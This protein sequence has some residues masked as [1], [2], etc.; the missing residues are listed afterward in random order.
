[1]L[2][3]VLSVPECPNVDL[4]LARLSAVL[5]SSE[6]S[7]KV[8]VIEDEEE[9]R[10]WHMPGSPTLL[11]DGVDPFAGEADRPSLSCR[12]HRGPDGG[13]SGTPSVAELRSV[14]VGSDAAS[15][16]SPVRGLLDRGGRGRLAP[17][18]RG[19]R[20]VQQAIVRAFAL[21]GRP[22][23]PDHL[24]EVARR[25]GRT[26]TEVVR[27]LACEDF[28]TLDDDG[29]IRAC[30][31]FSAPPSRHRVHIDSG[32]S[33]F[34]MCAIDALGI[35]V[36]LRRSGSVATTDPLTGD[37]VGMS[38]DARGTLVEG[39]DAAVLVGRRG[40]RGPAER[41]CCGVT[42]IFS[43]EHSAARWLALN[44][45][46]EGHLLTPAAAVDLARAVFGGMLDP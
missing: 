6:I 35:P 25:F 26:G 46:V 21:D 23:T 29:G 43:S 34:A 20:A 15:D 1:M 39:M 4:L 3:T 38:L 14:L 19:L 30:Y 17:P 22:P 40:A 28:V 41:I 12:L 5:G 42:N 37:P 31:P 16:A 10:R 2:L 32:P 11:I 44:T 7:P 18:A 24:D 36:M 27:D 33:V 9:A 8:I 13:V 45:D